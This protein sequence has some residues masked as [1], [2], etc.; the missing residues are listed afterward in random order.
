VLGKINYGYIGVALTIVDVLDYKFNKKKQA[1]KL[2]NQAELKL[3]YQL[4]P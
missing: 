4:Q 2:E 3:E 1:Q